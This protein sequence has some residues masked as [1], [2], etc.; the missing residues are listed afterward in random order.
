MPDGVG[1]LQHLAARRARGPGAPPPVGP[2]RR[3]PGAH[4]AGTQRRRCRTSS[5]VWSTV[6]SKNLDWRSFLH[7]RELNAVV[8]GTEFGDRMRAA[9]ER[10]I[11]QSDQ[12]TL[13]Q[14]RRRPVLVRTKEAFARLWQ[15]WL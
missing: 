12:V 7:N 5:G 15:Y 13:E 2:G 10:D 8:L 1:G 9:F 11:R 3:R 4:V 6:G 14:W